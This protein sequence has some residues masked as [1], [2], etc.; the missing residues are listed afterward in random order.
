CG[1][2]RRA[3]AVRRRVSHPVRTRPQ[4][5]PVVAAGR[6]RVRSGLSMVLAALV[7]TRRVLNRSDFYD[8]KL[9]LA[10][11]SSRLPQ[12]VLSRSWGLILDLF[13][14]PHKVIPQ[15]GEIFI[16]KDTVI[17]GNRPQGPQ[18]R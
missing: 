6:R 17:P 9:V 1:L 8:A 11:L 3:G 2:S 18:G 4:E 5:G 14:H 10:D 7:I 16:I 15:G 12:Y 13:C